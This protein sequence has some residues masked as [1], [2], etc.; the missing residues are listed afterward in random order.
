M[1]DT[2]DILTKYSCHDMKHRGDDFLEDASMADIRGPNTRRIARQ[3]G[4]LGGGV[5]R[6]QDVDVA[7]ERGQTE[8]GG[9][10]RVRE[11]VRRVAKGEKPR[12]SFWRRILG[13]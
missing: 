12:R 11:A 4:R 10:E 1:S 7:E 5:T 2:L 13:R 3:Q 8:E 6:K 9:Q